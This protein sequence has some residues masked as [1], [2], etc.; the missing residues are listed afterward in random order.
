MSARKTSN[1]TLIELLVV[2]AIVLVLLSLLMPGVYKAKASAQRMACANNLKQLYSLALLYVSDFDDCLPP[3]YDASSR[4]YNK[5]LGTLYLTSAGV[6]RMVQCPS[7]SRKEEIPDYRTFSLTRPMSLSGIAWGGSAS[8]MK[9][10][11]VFKPTERVYLVPW[12]DSLNRTGVS[13]CV[14]VSGTTGTGDHD[15][16]S[17]LIF[18][19]GN[20]NAI[21]TSKIQLAWWF[22]Q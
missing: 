21:Q 2:I 7:D 11:K 12:L 13:N 18:A 1:F 3:Y 10:S 5:I 20:V 9:M 17:N 4:P 8:P 22:N 15:D 6:N 19:A 14:Y 16:F